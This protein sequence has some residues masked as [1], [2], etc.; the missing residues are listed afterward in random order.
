MR[1]KDVKETNTKSP[2][3]ADNELALGADLQ[4]NQINQ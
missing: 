3:S 2:E 1:V 4:L